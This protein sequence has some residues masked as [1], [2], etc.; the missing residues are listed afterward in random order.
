MTDY[1]QRCYNRYCDKLLTEEDKTNLDGVL[2][3]YTFLPSHLCNECWSKFDGQKT[4]GRL[5]NT[6]WSQEQQ[7]VVQIEPTLGK[8]DNQQR[9]TESVNE[10]INWQRSEGV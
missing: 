6:G 3:E 9:Y 10:W 5:S 7:T 8:V 1:V 4:R 2:K